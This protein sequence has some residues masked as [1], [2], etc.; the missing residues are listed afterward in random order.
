[1]FRI[2][3]GFDSHRFVAGRPLVLGGVEIPH[4]RGLDGHSDADVL[5]H[6]VIDA[7]LGALALPDI[8]EL[9]PNTDARFKGISSVELLAGV[10]PRVAAAGFELVNLDATLVTEAPK[11]QP[12]KMAIRE[13][14]ATLLG[15]PLD[16][17]NLKAKSAERLGSIGRGEGMEAHCVVLLKRSE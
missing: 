15:V 13:R 12:H 6:A 7:L 8:G 11:L 4:E 14:L 9:F 1:M 5:L 17:V 2:G 16:A 10:L 3:H